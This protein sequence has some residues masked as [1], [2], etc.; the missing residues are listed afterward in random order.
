MDSPQ[1]LLSIGLLLCSL[2]C[3]LP[4]TVTSSPS[5]LSAFGTEDKAG[6]KLRSRENHRS[7]LSNFR[8]YLGDLIKSSISPAAIFALLIITALMGT[9]CCLT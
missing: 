9:L 5:P 7:W 3:L 1:K 4:E 6:S 8:E 2:S